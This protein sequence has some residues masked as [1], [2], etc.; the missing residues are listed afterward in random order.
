MFTVYVCIS[1]HVCALEVCTGRI[2]QD[3]DEITVMRARPG[4]HDCNLVPAWSE[5]K[6]TNFGPGPKEKLKFRSE[7]GPARE[8]LKIWAR[9][10]PGPK[11]NTK[12]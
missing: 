7:T 5:V 8:K 4:P 3:Y 10:R 2:F 11:R 6:K 9:V 12:F 1:V